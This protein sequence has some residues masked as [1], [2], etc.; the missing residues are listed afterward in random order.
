MPNPPWWNPT[1]L[2]H[3]V[4]DLAEWAGYSAATRTA[5]DDVASLV[6]WAAT[7]HR[8][9][10]RPAT[11]RPIICQVAISDADVI[12][13]PWYPAAIGS[14][15]WINLPAGTTGAVD[16]Y[17]VRLQGPVNTITS[18]H[19]NGVAL[20]AGNWRLD[21]MEWLVRTDGSAWPLWQDLAL[22]AGAVGTFEIVYTMGEPVPAALQAAAGDYALE[23]ARASS[24]NSS[25]LCR[26]PSRAKEI[27]RQ[28]V[29]MTMVEPT[30]L[31]RDQLTGIPSIDGVIRALNPGGLTARPRVLTPF[32]DAPVVG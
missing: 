12:S 11:A 26:L 22:P 30:V 24:P 2:H 15:D 25:T 9:D 6:L 5:S 28:G 21:Q 4:Q 7:G 19:I 13:A 29:S 23:W 16:P 14:G 31:L 18:V 27:T 8:F 1:H 17:R 3:S 10:A 20:P 32:M